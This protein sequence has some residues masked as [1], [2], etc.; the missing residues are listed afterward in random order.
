MGNFLPNL[1]GVDVRRLFAS[2]WEQALIRFVFTAIVIG[3][4][5]VKLHSGSD[6]LSPNGITMIIA[7]SYL[8]FSVLVLFSFRGHPERSMPGAS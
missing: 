8:A 1:I 5:L 2:E 3:Y 7:W 6:A 4:L